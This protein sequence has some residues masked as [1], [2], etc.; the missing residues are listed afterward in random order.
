MSAKINVLA[1][2][3][4]PR[5]TSPL[6]LATEERVI[7]E[8]IKL[9]RHRDNI[10]LTTCPATTVHDLRRALLN[11]DFQI[12]HISGH[13]TGI[14]L[15]LEDEIGGKY[16]VPQQGLAD[17][18]QA[19]PLI[20]CTILNA[21]YSIQQGHLNSVGVPFT[22]AM[23]G[24]IS[25]DA[26]I[27]FSRGFYDAIGAG[28]KIDFAYDEGCRSVKLAAPNTQFIS[29]LLKKGDIYTALILLLTRLHKPVP[30]N[31]FILKK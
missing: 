18:F 14:G 25:D 2:F 9:S 31:K 6:R 19:Y 21:C 3:A 8:S 23:E 20:E 17:L 24:P 1:V 15:V 30:T 7:R 22:I 4:N 5:G 29:K 11:E 26:A 16:V 28:R 27:E 12:I 13:G 10:S